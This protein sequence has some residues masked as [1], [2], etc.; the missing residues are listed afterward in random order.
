MGKSIG[1]RMGRIIG[2]PMY[3][4]AADPHFSQRLLK[5]QDQGMTRDE[6][7]VWQATGLF[8]K[9]DGR[10]YDMDEAESFIKQISKRLDIIRRP[11]LKK[12][13]IIHSM[14]RVPTNDILQRLATMPRNLVVLGDK[15]IMF[16]YASHEISTYTTGDSTANFKWT[17]LLDFLED[18]LKRHGT[19]GATIK[20]FHHRNGYIGTVKK[21][22]KQNCF[23]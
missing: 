5:A 16:G 10:H 4:V 22:K 21:I 7:G 9:L 17:N 12:K 1:T 11:T 8:N 2:H 14:W 20:V 18:S 6:I 19:I 3:T 23:F 15:R 13:M